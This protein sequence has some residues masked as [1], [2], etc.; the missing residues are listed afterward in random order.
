MPEP[1][2]SCIA[3]S[4]IGEV[5]NGL[6]RRY[7]P[8]FS[9]DMPEEQHGLP[10]VGSYVHHGVATVQAAFHVG[11]MVTAS[12]QGVRHPHA[13]G[14]DEFRPPDGVEKASPH[15]TRWEEKTYE[16]LKKR[17]HDKLIGWKHTAAA[18]SVRRSCG[19]AS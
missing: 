8:G 11:E 9:H 2:Q 6:E 16:R 19:S 13:R 3:P 14:H 1:V 7:A 4:H 17:A 12:P 18:A 15:A 5:G 10:S